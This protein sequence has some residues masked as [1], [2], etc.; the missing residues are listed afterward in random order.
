MTDTGVRS[1]DPRAVTGPGG[2]A[3]PAGVEGRATQSINRTVGL[4]VLLFVLVSAGAVLLSSFGLG[5]LSTF[6]AYASAE[7]R[8]S[9]TQNEALIALSRYLET[10]EERDY[11]T[12]NESMKVVLANRRARIELER[13]DGD[14]ARAAKSL[15]EGR[16]HPDEVEG[17]VDVF[18]RFR[19]VDYFRR[20][21]ALWRQGDA[22]M[23]EAGRLGERIRADLE[24][25]PLDPAKKIAYL[26]EIEQLNAQLDDSTERFSATVGQATRWMRGLL[27]RLIAGVALVMAA[28]AV[29]A[30]WRVGRLLKRHEEALVASER[31][32]RLLF[33]R[34]LAGLYRSTLDGRIIECNSALARILGYPSRDD[35][36]ALNTHELYLD[37]EDREVTLAALIQQKF[38]VN[39]EICLR[40]K[41]GSPVWVLANESLLEAEPGAPVLEG[42][43]IDIT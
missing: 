40:R 9:K 16:N 25:G 22:F 6:R 26:R 5:T 2:W 23:D 1:G 18:Q 10:R 12:F 11:E 34:N 32:Y 31:R 43:L 38:L 42:S 28:V 30:S 13:P 24:A 33:E 14:E 39:Y 19:N 4:L 29:W 41:D 37:P 7:S 15:I 8:W 35:V 3:A 20:A 17:M 21:M 27:F 36:L